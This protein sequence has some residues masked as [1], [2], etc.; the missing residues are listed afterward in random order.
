MSDNGKVAIDLDSLTF[1]ET[2]DFEDIADIPLDEFADKGTK[3]GKALLA[4]A[5]IAMRRENPDLTL[6]ELMDMEVQQTVDLETVVAENPTDA[7]D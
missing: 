4:L 1:R 3:K 2:I 6:D 5:F 7:D